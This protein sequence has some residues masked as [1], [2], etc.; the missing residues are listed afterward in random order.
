MS[1]TSSPPSTVPASALDD[2]ARAVHVV[3]V[4]DEA[5]IR[6][7]VRDYLSRHE[8][9][10]SVAAGGAE[11]RAIMA[12]RPVHLAIL[13]LAMPGEDGLSLARDLRQAGDLGIVML[14]ASTD[15][16][17]RIVGLELGA[18]D[19]IQKPFDPR[20]LLARLRS[21]VRRMSV[22][23][24]GEGLE[25]T[26]GREIRF[27]RCVLNLDTRRLYDAAGGEVA[28]TAMEFD[29]LK[30]FA[31]RPNRVLTRDQLLSL[32]HNR[33]GEAYDR[34]IDI[35]IMRL[36]KKIEDHPDKPAVLKTV[37]GSGYL[38]DPAGR[39]AP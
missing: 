22:S 27:G 25:G 38:F 31:E 35:R 19:W 33:D 37:R 18:D 15:R 4:D 39:A 8:F 20:E 30:A 29:L 1:G 28:I 17:D 12:E 9:V 13:D 3:V 34:S 26:I 14:T 7:L 23:A 2:R 24:R 21:L 11:L 6:D 32:A 5:E 36:R 10:V 16:I